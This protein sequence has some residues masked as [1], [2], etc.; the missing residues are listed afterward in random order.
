MTKM[1]DKTISL[2]ALLVEEIERMAQ[3]YQIAP[4]QL[5]ADALAAFI[6]RDQNSIAQG[7]ADTASHRIVRQGEIYWAQSDDARD[8]ASG[9]AHPYVVIQEDILNHSRIATVVACALTSNIRRASETPGN[10]LLDAGEANLPKQSVVEVS[11]VT[12]LAKARLGEYIGTLSAQ[13]IAQILA[14]MRFLYA[15]YFGRAEADG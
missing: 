10:V 11:K 8:A 6:T 1:V 3:T 4:D 15:S 14:G 9:V 2:P 7:N 5:V 12:T 13:R